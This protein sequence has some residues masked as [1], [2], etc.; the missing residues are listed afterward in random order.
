M[1]P[2][3]KY[4][5]II[6]EELI[7]GQGKM[8]IK[9][10]ALVF[11]ITI[12]NIFSC[13]SKQSISAVTAEDEANIEPLELIVPEPAAKTRAQ[14]VMEALFEAY[15]GV[16]EKVEY[17]DDDWA[18]L[19]KGKW[20]YYAEGRLL[21]QER[22]EHFT[23]YRSLSFYPYHAELPPWRERTSE[24]TERFRGMTNN[25]RQSTTRRSSYFLD[26]LWQASGRI[27]TE[28]SL[29]RMV[30]FG[31]QIRVHRSIVEN[32]TLI[33]AQ[34][35][36]AGRTNSEV[37]TWINSIGTVEGWHWRNIADTQS[38]SY[39]SYGLAVDIL[40]RTIGRRQTYWLWTSQYRE[41]WWN[42]SYSERYHPPAIVVSVFEDH[43]FIW[44][45]KW[46]LFDTMHFEYRPEI[47]ILNGFSVITAN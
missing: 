45:G 6:K 35:R 23:N 14:Q 29:Q 5:I 22:R 44:G 24:E 32:L 41:D 28:N 3:V 43:G 17:R 13:G 9:L 10:A 18:L 1:F 47:L 40:P 36:N 20:Y 37:Q 34:I 39:H 2:I 19:L 42:V 31:R 15:P 12:A 11:L 38:R 30:F 27:E 7:D 46:M 16:I 4:C 25:R 21:P 26:T 8:N 33:E